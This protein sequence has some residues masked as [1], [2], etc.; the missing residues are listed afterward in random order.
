MKLKINFR[1]VICIRKLSENTLPTQIDEQDVNDYLKKISAKLNNFDKFTKKPI[2]KAVK[3]QKAAPKIEESFIGS[4]S[5]DNK[6]NDEED[7][8]HGKK[9]F[10]YAIV[11]IMFHNI[12]PKILH[13]LK[14][15]NAPIYEDKARLPPLPSRSN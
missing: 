8:L 3:N 9:R 12:Y 4:K 1:Y 7:S 2:I 10:P 14:T 15:C 13:H 5:D 6:E 11:I